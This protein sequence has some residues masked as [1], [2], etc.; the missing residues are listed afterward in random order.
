MTE[1]EWMGVLKAFLVIFVF[2][3]PFI[4]YDWAVNLF[5]GYWWARFIVFPFTAIISTGCVTAFIKVLAED[6][7]SGNRII[8]II[9]LFIYAIVAIIGSFAQISFFA[10]SWHWA[11]WII[12][13][14]L[15]LL[16]SILTVAL[17]SNVFPKE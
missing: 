11:S 2:A 17:V 4:T 7:W 5:Q 12:G 13:I 3:I 10:N 15:W 6:K 16:L 14:I 1:K 9:A 8:V